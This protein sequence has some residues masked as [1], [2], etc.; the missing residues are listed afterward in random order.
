MME[1]RTLLASAAATVAASGVAQVATGD[2]LVEVK[3][4]PWNQPPEVLKKRHMRLPKQDD[5]ARQH[6]TRGMAKFV[7]EDGQRPEAK[8]AT[9]ALLAAHGE[10]MTAPTKLDLEESFNL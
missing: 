1:R 9:E 8:K 5:E 4:D 2:E 3:M 7:S 10:S 6:F